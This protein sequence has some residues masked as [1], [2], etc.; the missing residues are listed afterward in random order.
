MEKEH[1]S[2]ILFFGEGNVL[3]E[4]S[5]PIIMVTRNPNW[6]TEILWHGTGYAKEKMLSP[7]K[8]PT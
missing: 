1:I 5:S 2:G 4:E 3:F 8:R 7:F 6:S